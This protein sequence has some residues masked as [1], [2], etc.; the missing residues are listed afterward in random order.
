[1]PFLYKY[2]LCLL[3]STLL[4]PVFLLYIQFLPLEYFALLRILLQAIVLLLSPF[5]LLADFQFD[6]G[7]LYPV[8]VS[9][10]PVFVLSVPL[11]VLVSML[12]ILQDFVVLTIHHTEVSYT[13]W[14]SVFP[15]PVEQK[16]LYFAL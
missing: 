11:F 6:P 7:L 13:Y 16:T 9:F 2:K 3:P 10:P 14:E 5:V 8:L 12:P 4:L 1:M 15:L